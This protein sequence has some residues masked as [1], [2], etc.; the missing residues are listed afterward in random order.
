LQDYFVSSIQSI[1]SL[2]F[3]C[4]DLDF[5][6][7]GIKLFIQHLSKLQNLQELILFINAQIIDVESF[8]EFEHLLK[9]M[10][11]L[12]TF[13]LFITKKGYQN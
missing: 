11:N 5:E 12:K 13:Y 10:K 9:V 2:H 4:W 3:N 6:T 7:T 8:T 1:T